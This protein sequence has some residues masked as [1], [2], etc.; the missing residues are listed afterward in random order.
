MKTQPSTKK[1]KPKKPVKKKEPKFAYEI[2]RD[3]WEWMNE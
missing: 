3:T 2:T 1:E